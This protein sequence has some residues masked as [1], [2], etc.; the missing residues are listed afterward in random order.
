MTTTGTP[1]FAT[2]HWMGDG[3]FRSAANVWP[4]TTVPG[5]TSFAPAKVLLFDIANLANRRPARR[6]DLPHFT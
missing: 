3:V 4:A 5:S 6:A 2:T 1:S